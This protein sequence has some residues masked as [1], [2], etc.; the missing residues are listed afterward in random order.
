MLEVFECVPVWMRVSII[1]PQYVVCVCLV[2]LVVVI[3]AGCVF[4][5]VYVHVYLK[6]VCFDVLLSMFSFCVHASVP[7]RTKQQ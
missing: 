1:Q 7:T 4:L 3:A 6:C 5:H 2:V